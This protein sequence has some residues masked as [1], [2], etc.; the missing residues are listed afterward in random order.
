M[1]ISTFAQENADK[2]I[3]IWY[4]PLKDGKVEI[5]KK[6]N[7]YFGKLLTLKNSI[8]SNQSLLLD[9]NNP[10][11]TKRK[12]PLI[13]VE[14]LTNFKYNSKKDSWQGKLYD[15]DGSNGNTYD[16]YMTIKKDGTLNIKGFWGL[17]FFGLNKGLTL[18]KEQ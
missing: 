15:Y 6:D 17:S 5:Y 4:S 16:S 12:Q 11:K 18:T 10:D 9:A 3:G 7:F 13:G 14:F 8:D 1:S 2:I